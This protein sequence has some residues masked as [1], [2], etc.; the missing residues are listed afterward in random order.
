MPARCPELE[1]LDSEALQ[2]ASTGEAEL[3]AAAESSFVAATE[4][5]LGAAAAEGS[6]LEE[7]AETLLPIEASPGARSSSLEISKAT[8][9]ELWLLAGAAARA[10]ELLAYVFTFATARL[11]RAEE[12]AEA[13]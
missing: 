5:Q 8:C 2:L 12:L 7:A 1:E 11:G 6:Q 13:L 4:A 10:A 9:S 3:E